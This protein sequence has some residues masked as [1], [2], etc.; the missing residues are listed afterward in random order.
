MQH[1]LIA[2]SL[3]TL[4]SA[5][6]SATEVDFSKAYV[7]PPSE[8]AMPNE[9]QIGG[10]TVN[11]D[12]FSI[13]N[14]IVLGFNPNDSSFQLLSAG[15]Q[16]SDAELLAQRLRGSV[17]QGTYSSA[18]NHYLTELSFQSVQNGFIGGEIIHKTAD[19]EPSNFLRA[20]IAG[21]IVSQYLITIEDKEPVWQDV[22]TVEEE[23]ITATTPTRL[24]MRMKR[25]RALEVRHAGNGWGT[26]NEYRLTWENNHLI[27]SA[28]TPS[29]RF[30]NKD[31]MTGNGTIE[32]WEKTT[33]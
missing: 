24:L 21:D 14:S 13:T 3:L 17:W 20:T 7:I 33:D 30:D 12:D 19:S 9:M 11:G 4:L 18:K 16:T 22:E 1:R 15:Q 2:I 26:N 31:V 5:T 8:E 10:I 29:E 6:V 28:G 25:I 32:L 23:L 27:G